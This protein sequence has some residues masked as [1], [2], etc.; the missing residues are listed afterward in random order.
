MT[1]CICVKE[2]P[3]GTTREPVAGVGASSR[4]P[5]RTGPAIPGVVGLGT[6][7]PVSGGKTGDPLDTAPGAAPNTGVKMT[8]NPVVVPAGDVT[9]GGAARAWDGHPQSPAP[10]VRAERIAAMAVRFISVPPLPLYHLAAKW[11][12]AAGTRGLGPNG[13]YPNWISGGTSEFSN[14]APPSA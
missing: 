2:G 3:A 5:G 12:V 6:N 14:D 4:I 11:S 13:V 1:S 9:S 8:T 10:T 7:R